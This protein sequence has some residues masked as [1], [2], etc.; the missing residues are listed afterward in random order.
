[1]T[2]PFLD[3]LAERPILADGAMGT[4]L[5]ARGIPIDACFDVLNLHDPRAVQA[6]HREYV[7]A[8]ADPPETNTLGA[9][10]LKLPV[11]GPHRRGGGVNRAGVP[12]APGVRGAGGP[13]APIPACA[14]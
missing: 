8:G 7:T 6:I 5:Y 4:M 1:M 12:L 10:R 11:H 3:R 9:N 14:G 13:G 2:Q